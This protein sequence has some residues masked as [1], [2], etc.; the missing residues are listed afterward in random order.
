MGLSDVAKSIHTGRK[1][2]AAKRLFNYID[3]SGVATREKHPLQPGDSFRASSLPYLCPREEVLACK[4][5]V[6][7][8]IA[9]SPSLHITLEIG[10]SF[11]DLYRN[12]YYGPSGEWVG[13]WECIRCGWDTDQSGASSPPVFRDKLISRGKLVR[14]P[15]ECGSCG[16]PFVARD[17][18]RCYGTFK[19]WMVEDKRMHLN[20][21]PD[22]WS[23][24]NG[25]DRVLVDLK[26]H[27]FNGFS[28]RKTLRDGHDLQAWGYQH[29]CGDI[30]T[31]SEV[32]YLNK[33]PWGDPGAFVRD[34]TSAFDKKKFKI[35]VTDPLDEMNNGLHGGALPARGC[36]NAGCVRASE[37]QL[38]DVCFG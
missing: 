1:Q 27:G 36:I 26:S 2:S 23:R 16:A 12:K 11:H 22:G 17:R 32:W 34:I 5:E 9:M 25:M 19:E 15:I 33:S 31:P 4:Y 24:R 28:S 7:R 8:I 10:N 14:M 6:I 30:H 35:F 20:G 38:A 3:K 13:A 29:M 37:C 21:H 18:I